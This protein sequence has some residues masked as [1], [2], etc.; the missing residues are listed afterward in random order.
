MRRVKFLGYGFYVYRGEGRL[1]V[2]PKSIRKFKDK[3]REVTGR[4]NGMGIE[5]RRERL[6]QIVR[7]WFN[8][9]K[10]ADAKGLLARLDEWIRSRIRMLTWK[11]WKRVQTRF[12]NLKRAGILAEQAWQWANTRRGYWRTAHSP[13]LTGALSNERFKRVRC[14]SLSELYSAKCV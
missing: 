6:N 2:H 10:L 3:I 1:R 12:A 9:F 8:Y 13:I 7:S 14:L 5:E 11:R 4:S